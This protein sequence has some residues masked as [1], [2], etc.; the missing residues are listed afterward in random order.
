MRAATTRRQAEEQRGQIREAIAFKVYEFDAHGVEMNQRYRSDAVVTDGAGAGLRA[1]RRAALPADDL[2]RRPAAACL[3]V[4]RATATRSRR[5]T[6][7]GQGR[8]TVLTGIGGEG[9]VEAAKARRQGTRHRHRSPCDR[10]APAVA[11][12]HRRLGARAR[13]AR[14]RR[15]AGASGPA[16]LLAARERSPPIPTAR[17]APGAPTSILD[18]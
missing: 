8:F 18:R 16:R 17:T 5:S 13:G 1:G 10:P 11:G 12:F 4:R 2:A 15:R 6:L 9:W 3:A 7:T 14:Q